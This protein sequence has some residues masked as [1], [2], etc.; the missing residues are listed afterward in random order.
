MAGLR[1]VRERLL[2]EKDPG[3]ERIGS[4]FVPEAARRAQTVGT[5]LRVG[6]G[7]FCGVD[8]H[9]SPIYRPSEFQEGDRIVFGEFSGVEVRVD[10][11]SLWLLMPDEVCCTIGGRDASA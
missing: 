11:R 8:D 3:A 1:P 10:G 7:Y 6:P 9:G 4:L 5:V 2:V